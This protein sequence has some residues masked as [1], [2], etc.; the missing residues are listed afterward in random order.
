MQQLILFFK[1]ING[2]APPH[3]CNSLYTYLFGNQRYDFRSPNIPNPLSRTETFRCSFC[4][5]AVYLDVL[6]LI[7]DALHLLHTLDQVRSV[8]EHGRML[9]HHLNHTK[10]E[11]IIQEIRIDSALTQVGSRS[12]R[13]S[14]FT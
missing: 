2:P 11:H 5:R 4:P 9:L 7:V 1:I 3:L 13:A 10:E 8:P 12:N 14:E 6:H